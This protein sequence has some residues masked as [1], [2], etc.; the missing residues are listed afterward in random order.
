[1]SERKVFH[2]TERE[3]LM[4]ADGELASHEHD[5]IRRHLE[6]CWD[7]R[8]RM[9][10]IEGT[11]TQ[12]VHLRRRELDAVFPPLDG[13]KAE[14]ERLLQAKSIEAS[15]PEQLGSIRLLPLW[16]LFPRP[17]WI[18][19]TATV[20]ILF[21]L[22]STTFAPTLSASVLINRAVKAQSQGELHYQAIEY[23][24]GSRKWV[25]HAAKRA[26]SEKIAAGDTELD[27]LSRTLA[28]DLSDPLDAQQF[29]RWRNALSH[30]TDS[31]DHFGG[32]L[33]LTTENRGAGEIVRAH[34]VV[35]QHDYWPIEERLET[36]QGELITIAEVTPTESASAS[37]VS[38]IPERILA[39][40]SNEVV[41]P[42]KPTLAELAQS[43]LMARV[44]MHQIGADMGEEV[45]V[46]PG[47]S[48][49][50]IVGRTESRAREGQIKQVVA[51][52][53][54]V[55]TDLRPLDAPSTYRVTP[56]RTRGTTIQNAPTIPLEQQLSAAIPNFDERVEFVNA[57]L[58]SS[59]SATEHAWAL[60][61]LAK[62]Y[63]ERQIRLLSPS[64][65]QM[66]NLLVQ[67]HDE[68]LRRE[69]DQI[70]SEISR[71]LG[72]SHTT[73]PE[74]DVRESWQQSADITLRSVRS[75]H[76]TILTNL[77]GA[78]GNETIPTAEEAAQNLRRQLIDSKAAVAVLQQSVS[79]H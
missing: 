8:A 53:P 20:T 79:F 70:D 40:P 68:A 9:A 37:P 74:S 2:P 50:L 1:M 23:H 3:L 30:K 41:A 47:S 63:D 58:T 6:T 71:I 60:Q 62:R 17:I 4:A 22:I 26:K 28:F 7:C 59:E 52:V 25:R 78:N 69:L 72:S 34:F 42:P 55:Q 54:W 49:I 44:A 77:S 19:A 51:T 75:L 46:Q 57:I 76:E 31:I 12:Y 5:A 11:I 65:E 56:V 32:N 35:R 16:Q 36:R 61:H 29:A 38:R 18:S 43:E 64:S 73:V 39:N 15:V 13:P 27:A 14:L 21:V 66:L 10:E 45:R 24:V 67:S 48:A 33:E